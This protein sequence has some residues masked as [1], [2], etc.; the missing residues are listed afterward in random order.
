M[1]SFSLLYKNGTLY[2]KKIV[3]DKNLLKRKIVGN[4]SCG[5]M[6]PRCR[7]QSKLKIDKVNFLFKSNNNLILIRLRSTSTPIPDSTLVV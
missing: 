7:S 4:T 1:A 5:V 6:T 3:N 2:K